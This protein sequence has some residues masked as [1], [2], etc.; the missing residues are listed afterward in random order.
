[1]KKKPVVSV[2][3]CV[4][5]LLLPSGCP[6]P[7]QPRQPMAMQD[8]VQRLLQHPQ[9]KAAAQAAPEFTKEAL[10]TI[11]NLSLDRANHP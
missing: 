8:N 5:L 2:M 9:F 3:L 11:I 10:D 4:M 6:T 7:P 1:M